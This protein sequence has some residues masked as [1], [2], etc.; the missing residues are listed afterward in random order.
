MREP[1][2]LGQEG[3]SSEKRGQP[4]LRQEG[5]GS[6]AWRGKLGEAEQ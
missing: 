1:I 3:W 4:L 6:L 5:E 2:W